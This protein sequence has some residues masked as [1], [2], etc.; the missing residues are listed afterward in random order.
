MGYSATTGPLPAITCLPDD[1]WDPA[2]QAVKSPGVIAPEPVICE[3]AEAP[4]PATPEPPGSPPSW[5][6]VFATTV[7]LWRSRHLPWLRRRLLAASAL[8]AGLVAV[9]VGTAGLVLSPAPAARLPARPAPIPAPSG[10][11]VLPAAL[12]TAPQAARPTWLSVP[13]I[14]VRTSLVDLGLNKN[15]T[16]Q[17]PTSTAVAGWFTDSPRPGTVGSAVIVGHVDSRVGPGIFFWLR[18]LHPGERVYVGRAD[19]TMA[20]FT[21]TGIRMY[22]KDQFPTAAVYGPVPDAELRLITCG[23]VFDRSLGSYLSNVVVFARLTG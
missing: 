20:V 21:I 14:G 15:G 1:W 3:P 23:G 7:S 22:A 17:V 5:G 13:A 2:W 6:Q 12:A 16:L 9:A 11:A 10:R 8:A 18:I 19:G 4:A